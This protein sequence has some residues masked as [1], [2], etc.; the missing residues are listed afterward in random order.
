MQAMVWPAQVAFASPARSSDK[1]DYQAVSRTRGRPFLFCRLSR[2]G[3]CEAWGHSQLI[4]PWAEV[5]VEVGD[6][7]RYREMRV[8]LGGLELVLQPLHAFCAC[9]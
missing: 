4:N 9:P 2:H 1:N 6:I 7:V 8:G 3:Q 5:V